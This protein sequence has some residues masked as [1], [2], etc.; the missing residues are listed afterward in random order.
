MEI[1]KI[2]NKVRL[3]RQ[4]R[5]LTQQQLADKSSVSKGRIEAIENGRCMDMGFGMVTSIL[6]ALGLTLAIEIA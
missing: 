1:A 4:R 5:G 6:S 2:G 3:E